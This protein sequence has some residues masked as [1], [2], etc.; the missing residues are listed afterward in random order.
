MLNTILTGVLLLLVLSALLC[1]YRVFVGPTAADRVAALDTIG[2]LLI[3]FVGILMVIQDTTAY[4]EIILVVGLLAFAGSAA[5]ATFIE[6]G[7]LFERD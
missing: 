7:D 5:L 1:S 3:G 6:R 4:T 2:M